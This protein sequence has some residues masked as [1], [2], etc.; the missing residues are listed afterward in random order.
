MNTVYT[1]GYSNHS[2]KYFLELLTKYKIDTIIDVRSSPYSQRN[3]EFN[4]PLLTKLLKESK[5]HYIFM[6]QEL[7]ARRNEKDLY[8]NDVVDFQK[9]Y[10]NDKFISGIERIKLG[11]NKGYIIAIM[12]S[13]KNPVDCHRTIMVARYLDVLGIN[14]SHIL[15]DGTLLPH[16]KIDDELLY[17]YNSEYSQLNMFGKLMSKEEAINDS[18]QKQ[19]LNVGYK[20]NGD[21]E[22][23]ED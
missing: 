16:C 1:I 10:K 2:Y 23:E 4:K 18:Y 19:N 9:V 22:D 11:L 6:G 15:A 3:P 14:V 12:C 7:G 20:L 21:N 13:E 8:T 5:I 17:K